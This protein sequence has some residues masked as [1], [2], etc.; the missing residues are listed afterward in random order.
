MAIIPEIL[1]IV[2]GPYAGNFI[3]ILKN[4]ENFPGLKNLVYGYQSKPDGG[5]A[6]ALILAEEFANNEPIVVILGDNCT[7]ANI[8]KDVQNFEKGAKI[9]LKQV[10][11]PSSFGIA[12]LDGEKIIGIE[13][14]P[15]NPKSNYAVTGLYI[16]DNKVFD[17]IRKC[18]PSKRGQLEITEVNNFYLQDETL[19]W[20]ELYGF[21][22][23]TGT[24]ANLVKANMY[25]AK[26]SG[27]VFE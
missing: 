18:N 12:S 20:G 24:F 11:N 15:D 26:K 13:E 25:W 5:I 10:Q 6:D 27:I 23:D 19:T 1:F 9:F 16:Y 8:K 14:K 7:D 4:G 17:Y 2:S 3:S 22:Q 21:W